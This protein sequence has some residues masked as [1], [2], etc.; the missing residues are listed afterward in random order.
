VNN[1]LHPARQPFAYKESPPPMIKS[2]TWQWGDALASRVPAGVPALPSPVSDTEIDPTRLR[3][4]VT[5]DGT[6]SDV[7]LDQS[8]QKP[9]LDQQAILAAQKVR[10]QPANAPGLAWGIVTIAW[11]YTPKPQEV[12]PPTVPLAP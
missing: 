4:A 1:A 8:S 9:D 12:A 3:V 7:L 11:Y 10:F 2:T 5:P 6:V